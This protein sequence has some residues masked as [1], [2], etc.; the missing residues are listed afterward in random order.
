[1]DFAERVLSKDPPSD[2]YSLLDGLLRV[3]QTARLR[4]NEWLA[5]F[6]LNDGRYAVLTALASAEDSGCSQAELADRLGQSESNISTLIERM[7]RHGLVD[8][9]RSE[10]DRRKRVLLITVMGRSALANVDAE[11]NTW[12][13]R[14]FSGIPAGDLQTLA[15]LLR[16][17]GHRFEM[18]NNLTFVPSTVPGSP[19]DGSSNATERPVDPTDDPRT[20][21]FALA[22]MLLAL[23]SSVGT[24][25]V[26]KEAA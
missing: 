26:E 9:L 4:F 6:E 10:A 17:L 16:K 21:Q 22:Q 1:M 12:S 24:G 7:Q 8:R 14:M 25:L 3:S 13:A 11:R 5:H 23:S 20:P 2:S 18:S 15:V 19:S